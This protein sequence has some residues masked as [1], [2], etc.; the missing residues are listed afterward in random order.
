[1][2]LNVQ[3]LKKKPHVEKGKKIKA[4]LNPLL[5]YFYKL[6]LTKSCIDFYLALSK[7]LK[8]KLRV[9]LQVMLLLW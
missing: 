9:L 2:I 6:W 5:H 1:M 3:N 4:A 7:A 8:L